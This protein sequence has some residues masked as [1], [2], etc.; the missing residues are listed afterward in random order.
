MTRRVLLAVLGCLLLAEATAFAALLPSHAVRHNLRLEIVSWAIFLLAVL[1]LR[2]V[3][4]APRRMGALIIGAGIVFQVIA[5]LTP[6]TTSDDDVRYIWDAKV[7]LSGTDPYR[8][9][10]AAPQLDHLRDHFVLYPSWS[11]CP[12]P[13]PQG[14]SAINRPTVRT[15]YPPV[16][17][18]TFTAIR[19]LSF[20]GHGN[21]LPLQLAA[22]LGSIAVAWLLYRR[23]RERDRPLWTVALW[24]W[25]PITVIDYGN[26]AHIDWLAVLFA[27][28]A[29]GAQSSR[30][31]A[32]AGLL[33]GAAIA[34]KLYPALILPALV[35][36]RPVVVAAVAVA[37]V[38]IS[39][40]PHVLAVGAK[41]IGYL[42][43]YLREEHYT[44]GQRF[45]LLQP[46]LP[47][48]V[49]TAAAVLALAAV[50]AWV[51]RRSDPDR[52]EDTAVVM[53]GAAILVT[54]PS[55]GWYCGLLLALIALSGEVAWLPVTL[56]PGLWYLVRGDVD[57]PVWVGRVIFAAALGLTLV[58]LS[59]RRAGREG[60]RRGVRL[61]SRVGPRDLDLVAG[62]VPADDGR[63]AAR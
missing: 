15:I 32:K 19:L 18:G 31:P 27:V 42:P 47:S 28:L 4:L 9:P 60:D 16:A 5:V 45:L 40:V 22:A 48:R 10:P 6:P 39:Y 38:A 56:A 1:V 24:A 62:V 46:V 3:R 34:T 63:Q 43:G 33:A 26:N 17:E 61:A 37:T 21:H 7:Q 14:C 55:Y 30:R 23:R 51:V 58:G 11:G 25:C 57:A 8:Y 59:V 41:V 12:W 2:R 13:I 20:G 54:T 35:R 44:S 52:P 29:L 36:R 53:A 49:A 50:A